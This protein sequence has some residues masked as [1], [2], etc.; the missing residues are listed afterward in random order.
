[1]FNE[2]EVKKANDQNYE[3]TNIEEKN[4]KNKMKI[5]S[6]SEKRENTY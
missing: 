6:T 4:N 5:K 3:E 1:M 2:R